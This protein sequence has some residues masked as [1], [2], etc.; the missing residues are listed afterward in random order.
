MQVLICGSLQ[1][2]LGCFLMLRKPLLVGLCVVVCVLFS[3]MSIFCIT[4]FDDSA[5]VHKRTRL[6]LQT[7]HSPLFFREIVEILRVSPLI[8]MYRGGGRRDY[9]SRGRETNFFSFL[10]PN[11]SPR[12]LSRF[13]TH[14]RWLPV[15]ELFNLNGLTENQRTVNS[16]IQLLRLHFP[17]TSS[18]D[19]NGLRNLNLPMRIERK[20]FLT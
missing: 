16:L 17:I 18:L 3:V 15:I 6:Q 12:P 19:S 11:R 4:S 20:M 1:H 7:V 9:S 5:P 8:Q 14:P 13:D 2:S 10:L